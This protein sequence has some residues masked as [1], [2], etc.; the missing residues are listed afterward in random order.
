MEYDPFLEDTYTKH[1]TMEKEDITLKIMDTFEKEESNPDRYL[2]WAD[3]FIVVYSITGR[4]SFEGARVYLDS[5]VKFQKSSGKDIPITL[6]GNKVDLER[7][8][9]VSKSEGK[10]LATQYE[11]L[12]YETSA[13]E[14]Y[15]LVNKIFEGTL[16]ELCRI[17]ERQ[18]PLQPLYIT[19]DKPTISALLSPTS[20]GP[21]SGLHSTR[22]AKSPKVTSSDIK[23]TRKDEKDSSN[24]KFYQK[25]PTTFRILKGFK[26]FN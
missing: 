7:Y 26:L 13:A 4:Q 10:T 3:A 5:I 20:P 18:I 16:R 24:T 9:Q 6:V 12:F 23:D 17:K 1:E 25:K 8:R 2:K 15:E 19:E 14:D 22:R 11:C 21:F